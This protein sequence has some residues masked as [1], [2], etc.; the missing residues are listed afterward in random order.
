MKAK[1]FW[2][3]AG[4]Y[5]LGWA[6][7]FSSLLF[8]STQFHYHKLE[9]EILTAFLA[10]QPISFECPQIV[11]ISLS[12][13]STKHPTKLTYCT[14]NTVINAITTLKGSHIQHTDFDYPLTSNA[15]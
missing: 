7:P 12:S 3:V 9:G 11:Y 8:L 6:G 5:S 14:N 13:I 1:H 15:H 10:S 4:A 2:T